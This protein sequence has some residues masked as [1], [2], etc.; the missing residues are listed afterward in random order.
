MASRGVK[1]KDAPSSEQGRVGRPSRSRVEGQPGGRGGLNN[2]DD[3]ENEN[4]N[5]DKD[6]SDFTDNSPPDSDSDRG[7]VK[8][9]GGMGEATASDKLAILTSG[10]MELDPELQTVAKELPRKLGR[11]ARKSKKWIKGHRDQIKQV[12]D[13]FDLI[14]G[15]DSDIDAVWTR[16]LEEDFQQGLRQ[17]PYLAYLHGCTMP[18][19]NLKFLPMWKKVCRLC[20]QFPTEIISPLNSLEYGATGQVLLADGTSRPDPIWTPL[21]CELL[22]QLAVAGP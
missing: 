20:R 5:D 16:E 13:L 4:E 10:F 14:P 9:R 8:K 17:D 15:A 18:A 21:F 3:E 7:E 1:Q 12:Q 19:S 6:D 22:G 11:Q 2:E